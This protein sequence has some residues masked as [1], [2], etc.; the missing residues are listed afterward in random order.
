MTSIVYNST[1]EEMLRGNIDFYDDTFKV[2]FVTGNYVPNKETHRRRSD[3][4]GEVVGIGYMPGG[5]VVPVAV[6]RNGNNLEIS[7][8]SV[9]LVQSTITAAGAVY[10]KSSGIGPVF[11]ELVA[12]VDF[13]EDVVSIN[14]QFLLEA[15]K[16]SIQNGS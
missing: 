15:S 2:M 8:G 3:V 13:D 7:L 11:D 12:F 5:M 6:V 9:S 1:I 4:N 16:L 14:G 10:Y